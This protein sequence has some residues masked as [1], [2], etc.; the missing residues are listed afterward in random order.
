MRSLWR[1]TRWVVGMADPR[2]PAVET[3]V[4]SLVRSVGREDPAA[5]AW[6]A[7]DDGRRLAVM[8]DQLYRMHLPG[9]AGR[10]PDCRV[11]A[12]GRACRTWGVLAGAVAGWEAAEVQREYAQLARRHGLSPDP[13]EPDSTIG[14]GGC[15]RS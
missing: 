8:V 5:L 12:D 1:Y 7:G 11:P 6:L 14:S 2:V 9:V 15:A 3:F 4:S 10:C 13:V